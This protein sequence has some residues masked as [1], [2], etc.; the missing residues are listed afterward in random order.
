M[1][2][3]LMGMKH[4]GKSTVGEALASRWGCRYDD[5][6]TLMEAAYARRGGPRRTIREIFQAA[7]DE[8]FQR[9]ETFTVRELAADLARSGERRVIALG[10]RTPT[11][12][13]IEADLRRLGL[14]VYLE[15]EPDELFRR[16]ALGGMPPF[17]DEADPKADFL[18]LCAR[19]VPNYERL[20]DLK[21]NLDGLPPD[22]AVGRVAECIEEYMRAGQ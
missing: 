17:L 15:V 8:G 16:V 5:V 10:G 2:V 13:E 22:E 4:C 20:A 6:D 9:L 19:R 21:V 11:N 12:P 18:A 1:N 7:G 3:V 14:K